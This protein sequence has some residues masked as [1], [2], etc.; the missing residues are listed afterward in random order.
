MA[1]HL[2]CARSH[3]FVLSIRTQMTVRTIQHRDQKSAVAWFGY[4]M[5][6][7]LDTENAGFSV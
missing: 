4:A 5:S 6:D 2:A 7:R 3:Q 1:L